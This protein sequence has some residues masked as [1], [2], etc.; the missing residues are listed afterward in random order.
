[1]ASMWQI[2]ALAAATRGSQPGQ[3]SVSVQNMVGRDVVLSW[4]QPGRAPRARVSQHPNKP[5]KNSSV[6][7]IDSFETHEF[8]VEAAAPGAAGPPD[9]SGPASGNGL[10]R[11][12]IDT[13]FKRTTPA[14][15]RCKDYRKRSSSLEVRG[16]AGD[17][18][19]RPPR[20]ESAEG[21]RRRRGCRVESPRRGPDGAAGAARRVRGGVTTAPRLPRGE[22]AEES[23]RR[24][25]R[26]E[27]AEGSPRRRGR[28]VERGR[29]GAATAAWRVRG[30][31]GAA[32]A[33]R[34]VRGGRP[35]RGESAT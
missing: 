10:P 14:Y 18:P 33:K 4:L 27:S 1:M 11:S 7:A 5:F 8:V 24:L 15:Q 23:R 2:V 28:Y 29:T 35:L 31:I 3:I 9:G 26:G 17:G 20:G 13:P 22:S 34:R 6:M 32:A 16:V 25:P 30:G 12:W 19:P 21:S